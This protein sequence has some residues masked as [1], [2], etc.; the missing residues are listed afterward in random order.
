MWKKFFFLASSG[1]DQWPPINLWSKMS[2]EKTE[3]Y[4]QHRWE[5]VM[6]ASRTVRSRE[7]HLYQQQTIKET[8]WC[9]TIHTKLLCHSKGRL[10]SLTQYAAFLL[11][12]FHSC[13]L[14]LLLRV[15]WVKKLFNLLCHSMSQKR[16]T[17]KFRFIHWKRPLEFN[18]T[19]IVYNEGFFVTSA[20]FGT[21]CTPQLSLKHSCI[22]PKSSRIQMPLQTRFS[23][24][25]NYWKIP[26]GTFFYTTRV[27]YCLKHGRCSIIV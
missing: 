24:C 11:S 15:D 2:T 5:Y 4:V 21:Q 18:S 20:F 19:S 23:R 12:A 9:C 1:L 8:F 14:L 13:L 16:F 25:N 3:K 27:C 6:F 17:N 22:Q 7:S 26:L 10:L